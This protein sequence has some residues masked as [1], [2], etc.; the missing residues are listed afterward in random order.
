MD[1]ND[2]IRSARKGWLTFNP[3]MSGF[4]V[5][6][7]YGLFDWASTQRITGNPFGTGKA[8]R[9]PD[10]TMQ[11]L[12]ALKSIEDAWNA[13]RAARGGYGTR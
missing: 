7:R 8:I 10:L 2:L 12:Q 6:P 3:D 5:D 4:T 1:A 9:R 13:R 11:G